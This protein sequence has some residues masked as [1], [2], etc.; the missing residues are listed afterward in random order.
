MS[1]TRHIIK[2]IRQTE[3]ATRLG[4]VHQYILEVAKAANKQQIRQAAEQ[5]FK[6]SVLKVNTQVYQGKW[7]RLTGRWGQRADWKKAIVTV[8]KGQKIEL[9]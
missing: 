6:V 7:R 1:E 4:R 2:G 3:K 8:A 9:K 5:V